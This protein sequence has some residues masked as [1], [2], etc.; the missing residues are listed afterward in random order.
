M[1][2][3]ERYSKVAPETIFSTL[4]LGNVGYVLVAPLK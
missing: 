3:L 2:M 4:P 1:L